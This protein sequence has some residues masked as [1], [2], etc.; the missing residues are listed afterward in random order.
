[1]RSL[2]CTE[3]GSFEYADVPIPEHTPGNALLAI[4]RVGVCGTDLHA[5]EG[6]QPYFSYPRVL[7]HELA[8][9]I[10]ETGGAEGFVTGEHVTVIPYFACGH[11]MPCRTG[12]SNCCVTLK[13]CGVHIDGGMCPCFSVP[14]TSLVHGEGLSYDQLALVEPLAIGAHAVKRAGITPGEFV[15]VVGAGPIGLATMEFAR[16]AGANVIAMDLNAERLSFCTEELRI[17]F[18]I[19]PTKENVME[20]L[21]QVTSG[22]MPVVVMDA[23]GNLPA[24]NASFQY[25]AHGGRYI[26]VGLQKA[27]ISVSHPEFHKRE[28]TLLSS[29][30]ATREDFDYVIRSIKNGAVDPLR[31]IT[32]RV[33]FDGAREAFPGWLLPENKVIKAMITIT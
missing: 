23:T 24:I 2:V 12:R 18:A 28:A 6:T 3:P 4:R 31:Y 13:V 17:P 32:H 25:L 33:D 15:L 1:M 20:R 5:F 9:E 7:G 11:C 16:I 29:R 26:L 21:V 27:E 8:A 30:N 10:I 19:N 14:V 22:D